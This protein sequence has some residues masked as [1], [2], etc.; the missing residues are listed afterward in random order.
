MRSS[1]GISRMPAKPSKIKKP[2][3][4]PASSVQDIF[5]FYLIMVTAERWETD[6]PAASMPFN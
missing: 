2:D 5:K 3:L 1:Q 4:H 6:F